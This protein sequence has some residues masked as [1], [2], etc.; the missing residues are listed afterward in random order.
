MNMHIKS[1]GENQRQQICARANSD[2]QEF[3]QEERSLSSRAPAV[4]RDLENA[5]RDLIEKERELS[6]QR[7][8]ANTANAISSLPIAGGVAGR[9]LREGVSA[10]TGIMR[11]AKP[12]NLR[13]IFRA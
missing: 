1:I 6:I 8:I 12:I 5:K 3:E 7:S 4:E 2:L 10:M 11:H 9:A 13:E